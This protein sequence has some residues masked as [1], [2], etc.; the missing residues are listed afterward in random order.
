MPIPPPT[1][2]RAPAQSSSVSLSVR[3]QLSVNWHQLRLVST[4]YSLVSMCIKLSASSKCQKVAFSSD[5]SRKMTFWLSLSLRLWLRSRIRAHSK[6]SEAKQLLGLCQYIYI[7]ALYQPLSSNSHYKLKLTEIPSESDLCLDKT[8][9]YHRK[10][11]TLCSQHLSNGKE[12]PQKPWS[13]VSLSTFSGLP[14]QG[15]FSNFLLMPVLRCPFD[16]GKWHS[17]LHCAWNLR[18]AHLQI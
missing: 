3:S 12:R 9:F 10:W 8:N 1:T 4:N 7:F 6:L 16:H 15:L 13:L 5:I 14:L 18:S 2:C 11:P 17:T